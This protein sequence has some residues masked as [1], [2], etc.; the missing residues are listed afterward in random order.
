M[1]HCFER[2]LRPEE[3]LPYCG[4]VVRAARHLCGLTMKELSREARVSR[5][6]LN[7][8]ELGHSFPQLPH[9]VS[10]CRELHLS[11]DALFGLEADPTEKQLF[12]EL[13]KRPG[14]A[15]AFLGMLEVEHPLRV[16][17]RSAS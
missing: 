8:L 9:F 10:I 6:P 7:R 16:Q 4:R 14:L 13:R 15:Q 1:A 12:L 11:M 3:D 2:P 17:S 5:G